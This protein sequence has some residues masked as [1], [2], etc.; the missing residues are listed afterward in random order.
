MSKVVSE[1]EYNNLVTEDLINK[2]SNDLQEKLLST[3]TKYFIDGSTLLEIK[4]FINNYLQNLELA[5][6]IPSCYG[7]YSAG[8]NGHTRELVLN[9]EKPFFRK[10]PLYAIG[11]MCY[12]VDI[13]DLCGYCIKKFT[14]KQYEQSY[15]YLLYTVDCYYKEGSPTSLPISE[16]SFMIMDHY[17]SFSEAQKALESVVDNW[18]INSIDEITK[19][20][21]S[22]KNYAKNLKEF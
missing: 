14:V 4:D 22:K 21:T 1:L 18:V 20:G 16:Y 11:Y 17:K 10:T 13:D 9:Y 8:F 12:V 15:D 7:S 6:T 5:G 2:V 19:E 3:F